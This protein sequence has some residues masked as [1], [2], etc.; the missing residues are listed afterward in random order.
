MRTNPYRGWNKSDFHSCHACGAFLYCT[1]RGRFR[2]F[3]AVTVPVF[4]AVIIV[5][6]F[7]LEALGMTVETGPKPG[8]P[9]FIGGLLMVATL[10][11]V[12]NS[13]QGRLEDIAAT[14]PLPDQDI[15][16]A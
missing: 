11:L 16:P 10:I 6:S 15:V 2:R 12:V 13:I 9:T 5:T 8:E 14:D 4:F 3:F 1:G 7:L